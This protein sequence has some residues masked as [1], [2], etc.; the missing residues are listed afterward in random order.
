MYFSRKN[1]LARVLSVVDNAKS[2]IAGL[3]HITL[4]LLMTVYKMTC[5]YCGDQI[6]DFSHNFSCKFLCSKVHIKNAFF[7]I[8]FILVRFLYQLYVLILNDLKKNLFHHLF[9]LML[10]QNSMSFFPLLNTKNILEALVTKQ[11]IVAIIFLSRLWNSMATVNCLNFWVNYPF[12]FCLE[13]SFL[14]LLTKYFFN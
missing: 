5:M 2:V 1:W 6:K 13:A 12:K 4:P 7:C 9:A 3:C 10:F 11:L 14:L 8:F